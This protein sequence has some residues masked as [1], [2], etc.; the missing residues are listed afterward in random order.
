MFKKIFAALLAAVMVMSIS[1]NAF[2]YSLQPPYINESGQRVLPVTD[3]SGRTVVTVY[4]RGSNVYN[5]T[6]GFWVA[7]NCKGP[8]Y[9]CLR[10]GTDGCPIVIMWVD[11]SN[12]LWR[13]PYNVYSPTV[14]QYN[15]SGGVLNTIGNVG[16]YN[17]QSTTT[18]TTTTYPQYQQQTQYPTYQQSQYPTY[19]QTYPTYDNYNRYETSY[20]VYVTNSGNNYKYH[21]GSKTYSYTYKKDTLEYGSYEISDEAQ[22]IGFIEDYICYADDD[23]SLYAVEIGK[24]SHGEKILEDITRIQYESGTNLISYVRAD[25]KKYDAD[26]LR[27][28]I[29]DDDDDDDDDYPEV[30]KSSNKYTYYKSSSKKYVYTY[31]NGEVEYKDDE[32]LDDVSAIAFSEGGYLYMLTEDDDLYQ[33]KVGSTSSPKKVDSDIDRIKSNNYIVKYV[34]DNDD[35]KIDVEDE[36]E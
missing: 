3:D 12:T 23:N 35:N 16:Y 22:A 15:Y 27:D 20:D 18:Q 10:S 32:V 36:Y 21:D 9:V 1:V 7:S 8:E 4:A 31:K 5:G 6:Y 17:T 30:K 19:Q 13:T 28:L 2:A 26:D 25:G 34:Y 14:K 11:T 33:I 29:D 24:K